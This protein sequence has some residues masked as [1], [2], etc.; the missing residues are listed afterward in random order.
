M[1]GPEGDIFGGTLAF[2]APEHI[3]AFN[4]HSGVS[5]AAVDARSDIYSLGLVLFELLTGRLPFPTPAGVRNSE[6]LHDCAAERRREAPSPRQ[7]A[8]VPEVLDRT[9][10]RCL[11]PQPERRYQSAAELSQA[12][13]GCGEHRRMQK[14]LPA[15]GRLTR[16]VQQHPFRLGILLFFLPHLL[17]SIVNITY[18]AVRIAG[19]LT[20]E[21]Q[22]AFTQLAWGY[23]LVVYPLCLWAVWCLVAPLFR[24]WKELVGPVVPANEGIAALRRRLLRLSFWI[25]VLACAGWLPGSVLFPFGI[26]LLAGPVDDAVYGHFLFSFTISGLIALTYSLLAVEFVVIR[27]LYPRFWVDAH[28]LRSRARIELRDEER[29]LRLLQLLAGLIP[30]AGAVLMIAVGPEQFAGASYRTFRLLVTGLIA[31]GMFGFS[32][33]LTASAQLGQ[34]LHALT[35]GER[36]TAARK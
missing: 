31:L 20:V 25:V 4:T 5:P 1:L 13:T 8:D 10:R 24:G 6:V 15:A 3:D 2:M 17:G 29:Q 22:T 23:N 36:Q 7:I 9:V 16:V 11:D 28:D 27:V 26:D 21:Q 19:H 18:N 14:D 35:G 30:L 32:V 34:A 12:L 33:A